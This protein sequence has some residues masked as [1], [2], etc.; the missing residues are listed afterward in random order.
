MKV[1][2]PHDHLKLGDFNAICDVCGF[3]FKGSMLR[4]RWDGLMVCKTDWE[5]RHPQDLIKLPQERPAPPWTRPVPVDEFVVVAPV[6]T[7][8]LTD[9]TAT[10]YILDDEGNPVFTD[11]VQ[12]PITY[13]D[14]N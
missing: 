6:D 4:K 14:P 10:T 12:V 9:G 8:T 13:K 5:P 3:K 2:G 11:P 1:L 7:S